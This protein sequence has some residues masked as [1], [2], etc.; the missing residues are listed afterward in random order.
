MLQK[1]LHVFCLLISFIFQNPVVIVSET[2]LSF[3]AHTFSGSYERIRNADRFHV[4]ITHYIHLYI[5]GIRPHM[6]AGVCFSLIMID[7]IHCVTDGAI[8]PSET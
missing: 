4:E 3:P 2:V 5:N 6:T 8:V 7:N 1:Y